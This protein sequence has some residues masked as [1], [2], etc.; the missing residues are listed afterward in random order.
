MQYP[1]T[2][3]HDGHGVVGKTPFD[4]FD[5]L[6][7]KTGQS[8]GTQPK[9]TYTTNP[10]SY[11]P[12]VQLSQRLATLCTVFIGVCERR[13][14]VVP[15]GYLSYLGRRAELDF[16]VKYTDANTTYYIKS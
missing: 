13:Y 1:R 14:E 2:S 8:G 11:L 4:K 7:Y 3:R 10:R 9:A 6:S 16:E 5:G 15:S 12:W